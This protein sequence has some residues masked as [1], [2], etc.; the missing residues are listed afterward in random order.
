MGG[1]SAGLLWLA[2]AFH[3][4]S[5]GETLDEYHA[6]DPTGSDNVDYVV[7][8]VLVELLLLQ[9]GVTGGPSLDTATQVTP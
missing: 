8:K 1:F 5:L 9:T 6:E 4:E 2:C 3:A 7:L